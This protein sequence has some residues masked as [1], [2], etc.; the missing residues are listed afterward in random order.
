[1]NKTSLSHML[2]DNLLKDTRRCK[3]CG[4]PVL[5]N[6]NEVPCKIYWCP[7]H[8]D[9]FETDTLESYIEITSKEKDYLAD[10]IEKMF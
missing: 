2:V 10:K 3:T 6:T 7:T 8:G 9:L 5:K 1:M 4:R